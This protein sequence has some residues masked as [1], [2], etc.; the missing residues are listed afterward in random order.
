VNG[1]G[2]GTAAAIEADDSGDT[3]APQIAMDAAGNAMVVWAWASASG[4]PFSYN[5]WANRY[6]AGSGWGSAG[7]IDSVN[8]TTA[9]PAPHV[10]LDGAGNAI[11]VWHRPD[12]SWNSIWSSRHIVA[13]GWGAPV[14]LETDNTNSAHDARIAF[15]ASGNA[16]AVWIQSDGVLDNV[17]A[18]RYTSGQGWGSAVLIET[19]NAGP[20]LEPRIAFDGNGN[21][22]AAWSHRDVAGFTFNIL[23][24]RWTAATGWGTAAPIDNAP[25]AA[26]A[27]QLGVDGS[28]NVITVWSQSDGTRTNI[29]ANGFR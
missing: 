22:T 8:A 29:W 26:R 4:P 19:D 3:S 28:G 7:P 18:N 10:A 21:A 1:A 9:N 2:W 25:A 20:A 6:T 16:M 27:P 24:N 15:D 11:A 5:V 23:A 17:L 13:S 12:G 14:L